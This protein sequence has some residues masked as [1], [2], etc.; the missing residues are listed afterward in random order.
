MASSELR[1][2]NDGFYYDKDS[3]V[4]KQVDSLFREHGYYFKNVEGLRFCK[5]RAFNDERVRNVI[6][7]LL[8]DCSLGLYKSYGA[9]DYNY[10]ILNRTTESRTVLLVQLWSS[11]SRVKFYSGSHLHVLNGEAALTGLLTTPSRELSRTEITEV[12][13]GMQEGGYSIVDGRTR[14]RIMQG[15]AV[16]LAFVAPNE[17]V[18]WAK[19]ELPKL[20]ELQREVQDIH[21]D[22]SKIGVNFEFVE[23]E[24][25]T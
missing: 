22:S 11:G 17:L 12:T 1:I 16:M 23:R 4:G 13:V 18:H 5:A 10:S 14:F 19:M 21:M 8:G 25:A 6:E 9:S 24:P 2:A 3:L 20:P 15:R 7:V